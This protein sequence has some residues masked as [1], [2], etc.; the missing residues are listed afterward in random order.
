MQTQDPHI[1]SGTSSTSGLL[2]NVLL[3][4]RFWIGVFFVIRLIGITNP[5][6]EVAHN[7][8]QITGLMVAR[9]FS[10]GEMN[11]FYPEVDETKGASGIIG[12]E[13][14]LLNY[15]HA[16]VAKVFGYKH[17]Y[18]RLIN[19]IVSSFGLLFFG[20]ILQLLRY[21]RKTQLIAT[22]LLSASL[23]FSFSRKTMPD[24]FS[25]SLMLGAFLYVLRFLKEGK[26]QQL[27]FMLILS[28]FGLL[29]KI[30]SAL[31]FFTLLPFLLSQ[32]FSFRR[33]LGVIL[34]SILPFGLSVYWYFVWCKHLSAE[35]G[36]WY[37]SG[38]SL[39]EGWA[40]ISAHPL[41]VLNNFYFDAFSGYIVFLFVLIGMVIAF[42]KK[43]NALLIV[44]GF[45]LL[46]GAAL[47]LKSGHYFYHHNYYI[48]P[49]VPIMAL[50]AAK[51]L[52]EIKK[53]WL[54][55]LLVFIGVME[56][57]LN[58]QHDLFIKE[59]EVYKMELPS[60][61]DR[62]SNNEDLFLFN[63]NGNPQELYLAHRKGWVC[64]QEELINPNYMQQVLERGGKY[65][66]FNKRYPL[67][68]ALDY[69]KIDE[70]DHYL[71]FLLTP[72]N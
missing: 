69:P 34:A 5:P 70:N 56:G 30:P 48:L 52:S 60:F 65:L 31:Y 19:L 61:V 35:F 44:T 13:F 1:S 33:R 15:L 54:M 27:V 4:F 20:R 8:R 51:A 14:P 68:E 28:T 11:V 58:Q 21:D 3:D 38:T 72:E 59:S 6:L 41:E 26:W 18:G 63:S 50:F 67:P 64:Y 42:K 32:S 62:F 29:S 53:A 2:Q 36:N 16:G 45:T 57:V 7:W 71:V 24:T 40:E 23:W 9:N 10:E 55:Y 25:L 49:F 47:I 66:V 46:G 43:E 39:T 37:N 22:L 17:W 12:M